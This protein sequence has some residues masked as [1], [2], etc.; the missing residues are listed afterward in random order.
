[1]K[2]AIVGIVL[3]FVAAMGAVQWARGE[4]PSDPLRPTTDR[5]TNELRRTYVVPEC[6][7]SWPPTC[8]GNRPR[9][10]PDCAQH[11]PPTCE[12]RSVRTVPNR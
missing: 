6:G 7:R 3:L 11:W 2:A 8:P 12:R 1:M 5:I 4:R 9:K 10:V